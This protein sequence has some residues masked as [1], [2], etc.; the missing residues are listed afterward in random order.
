MS[1]AVAESQ[2]ADRAGTLSA[3][4]AIQLD[5][6]RRLAWPDKA[7]LVTAF[8][9]AAMSAFACAIVLIAGETVTYDRLNYALAAWSGVAVLAIA[10]PLWLFMRAIDFLAGGPS[11]RQANGDHG[12]A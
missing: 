3:G 5:A 4:E 7:G 12:N 2:R 8:V 9:I 11:R 1:T 10:A 6:R